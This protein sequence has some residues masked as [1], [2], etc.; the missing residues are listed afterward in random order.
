M[1]LARKN[2][3]SP[4]S[5]KGQVEADML[6]EELKDFVNLTTD[7]CYDPNYDTKIGV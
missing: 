7:F 2:G 1:H 6:R 5:E 3:L 4:K